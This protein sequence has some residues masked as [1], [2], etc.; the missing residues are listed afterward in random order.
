MIKTQFVIKRSLDILLCAVILIAGIPILVS[1]AV[2]VKL[3]SPG[4]IMFIQRRAGKHGKPFKI[5]KFRT[6]R[7]PAEDYQ[8]ALV[9]TQMDEARITRVGTFLR[10]Y[11]LDELPQLLNILRGQMSI[12]GPRPLLVEQVVLLKGRQ[13]KY[14]NMRPGVVTYSSI[15]GRRSLT[16][17]QKV[18]LNVWYVENWSLWLD[19]KILF[20]ALFVVILRKNA[21]FSALEETEQTRL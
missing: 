4:P 15:R 9:W 11:G 19:M 13:Q 6:M 7:Q 17:E 18:A 12:V 20:Q 5:Y 16:F 2:A 21:R 1:L 14:L 10:D 8:Q 3:S